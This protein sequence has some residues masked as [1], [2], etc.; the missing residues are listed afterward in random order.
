[1]RSTECLLVSNVDAFLYFGR[2]WHDC[3]I[4]SIAM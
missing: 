1:M 3:L 2:S 4:R